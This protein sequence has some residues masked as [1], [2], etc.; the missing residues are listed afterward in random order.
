[1]GERNGLPPDWSQRY[2]AWRAEALPRMRVKDRGVWESYPFVEP[3]APP[4]QVPQAALAQMRVA[5]VSSAGL[6]L[7]RQE[8]FDG[9][10]LE[11]DRGL[12]LVPGSGPLPAWR[13][14]HG[15][16]DPAAAR[17]D[18][19]TVFPLDALRELAEAGEMGAVAPRHVS[20]VGYQIDA[21]YVVNE[22]APAVAAVLADDGVQAALLVPV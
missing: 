5:L 12:R 2:A 16:Y 19:G 11:G 1:M 15:H 3:G 9:E 20:F 7:P 13:I 10:S 21:A 6:T 14:D 4:L 8:P 17:E 22:L 18:Y